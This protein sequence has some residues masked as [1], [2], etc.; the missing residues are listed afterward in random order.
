MRGDGN[1]D[2]EASACYDASDVLS[3][4]LMHISVRKEKEPPNRTV[5][6]G[7]QQILLWMLLD[8]YVGCGDWRRQKIYRGGDAL[9]TETRWNACSSWYGD[10]RASVIVL[11]PFSRSQTA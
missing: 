8:L 1:G 11:V 9:F 4:S 6:I 5:F 7:Y 2:V 3:Q 10:A